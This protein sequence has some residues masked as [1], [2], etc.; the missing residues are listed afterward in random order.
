[1]YHKYMYSLYDDKN[2]KY[3]HCT[4]TTSNWTEWSTIQKKIVQVI[5]KLDKREARG[6]FEIM[7][8]F[9]P[10]LYHMRSNY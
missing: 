4:C 10:E 9:L 8:Q 7:S 1:M 2:D 3:L 6:R 5:L